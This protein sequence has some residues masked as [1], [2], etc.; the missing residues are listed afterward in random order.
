[1]FSRAIFFVVST[2][3]M[4][5][6]GFPQQ[7]CPSGKSTS[8]FR[9]WRTLK[10]DSPVSGKTKSIVQPPKKAT[11]LSGFVDLFRDLPDPV[12]QRLVG[13]R[14]EAPVLGQPRQEQRQVADQPSRLEGLLADRGEPQERMEELP[15]GDDVLEGLLEEEGEPLLL[16]RSGCGAPR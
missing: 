7:L 12:A 13:D 10:T 4:A 9:S 14:R 15:V 6:T 3:P 5:I 8:M 2:S 16:A 1:M 11:R